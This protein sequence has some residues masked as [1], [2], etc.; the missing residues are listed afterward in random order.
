MAAIDE[1]CLRHNI[2]LNKD[3]SNILHIRVDRR[4][5]R[6]RETKLFGIPVS[7]SARYLGVQL[8]DDC[9]FRS[10]LSQIAT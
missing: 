7:E 5:R 10:E 4:T 8:D 1:W 6:N 9:S 3:K 2:S